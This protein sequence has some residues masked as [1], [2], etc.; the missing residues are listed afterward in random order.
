MKKAI[1][2]SFMASLLV[3]STAFAA[4]VTL[5]N[6]DPCPC[7][8]GFVQMQVYYFG[9]DNV[10]IDVY[11]DN[12]LNAVDLFQSFDNVMSGD[13]LTIDGTLL[14]SGKLN[15]RT[16]LAFTPPG[17]ATCVTSIYSRC[18][19]NP[20]PN[21]LEELKVLGKTFGEFTVYSYTDEENN[22]LCTIENADQ[23]W[24]VGGNVVGAGNKTLGTRNNEDVI[25]I[26]N[27]QPRGILTRTGDFGWGTQAPAANFDLQGDAIINETLDV[28]GQ[29]RVNDITPSTSPNTGALLVA[30][31]VGIAGNTYI[32][33]SLDVGQDAA[34][35][36]D[37]TVVND[38][39]FGNNLEVGNNA[40]VDNDLTVLGNGDIQSDL[41]VGQ[42][43]DVNDNLNVGQNTTIGGNLTVNMQAV[44]QGMATINGFTQ[45]NNNARVTNDL[46]V[47]GDIEVG[48]SG[49]GRIAYEDLDD[50]LLIQ[51]QSGDVI[52]EANNEEMLIINENQVEAKKRLVVTGADL[53][54][55]FVISGNFAYL[56]GMVVSIDPDQ[57]GALQPSTE[58][59]DKKVAGIISGAGGVQT[60]MLLGQEGTLADGEVAVAMV[61]R[62]YCYAD[63]SFGAIKP[64]DLLTTS[65]TSGHIMKVS[66][67]EQAKGAIIGKAM[68][69]IKK[70]K[71]LVLVLISLQ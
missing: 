57:P 43:A 33:S 41:T 18:P 23:D 67:Y 44:I 66:D 31:G 47:N 27:D 71:G 61:G 19:T 42:N 7:D 51:N 24:H 2:L 28:N 49:N 25:M 30:G 16:Y 22:S 1:I 26:S 37:L 48:I 46:A 36:N 70:G 3:M 68:T 14:P 8:G 63:A 53:A 45:V 32:N 4:N 38:G 54:E 56:P 20:Y 9:P 62:V 29:T 64:G 39:T 10:T 11:S 52:I 34:V 58:A 60:A 69:G 12:D 6:P 35:G 21:A 13:L 50:E 5:F 65:P 40:N 59:Y 15:I 55:R 17:E